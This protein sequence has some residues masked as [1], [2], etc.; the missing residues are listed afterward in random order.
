MK[1]HHV[2]KL[3]QHSR[4][5]HIDE[6]TA[7]ESRFKAAQEAHQNYFD[8]VK[9]YHQTCRHLGINRDLA[10]IKDLLQLLS[11]DRI[12]K[13]YD[14]S[15][16]LNDDY[17]RLTN[18]VSTIYHKPIDANC[19][20]VRSLDK[21]IELMHSN[22][23]K[24]T[25]STG[26][27]GRFSFVPRDEITHRRFTESMMIGGNILLGSRHLPIFFMGFSKGYNTFIMGFNEGQKR[28]STEG[29]TH[30][31]FDEFL[32][33]DMLRI[34]MGFTKGFKE[35]LKRKLTSR[36]APTVY[37]RAIA[38]MARRLSRYEGKDVCFGG[39][40]FM[41]NDLADRVLEDKPLHLGD[42]SFIGSGGGWKAAEEKRLDRPT[43][44]KKMQEAF[45][46]PPERSFDTYGMTEMNSTASECPE[47]R[48]KHF[49]PWLQPIILD[50][51]LD[52]LNRVGEEDGEVVEGR[53][54]FL[55]LLADSYPGFI[56]TGDKLKI[57]FGG[58]KCGRTGPVII[59]E[60][61]R[62]PAAEGRGCAGVMDAM[63]QR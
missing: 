58:C 63:I 27:S 51:N 44:D 4:P 19:D 57:D 40:P 62:M 50:E 59:D 55:D 24:I 37:R 11:P 17:A 26:T 39:A 25:Y 36:L 22:G 53:F 28:Y 12:F 5:Y 56:I 52:P 30:Y 47:Y 31:L 45:G 3:L 33:S 43:F 16:I 42:R 34:R 46:I 61:H 21:W 29:E 48:K 54:A 35:E 14:Y 8:H 49:Q 41:M 60:I 1:I 7:R 9:V 15:W 6:K 13:S 38:G 20:G 2:E 32:S 23:V 18:W 10:N